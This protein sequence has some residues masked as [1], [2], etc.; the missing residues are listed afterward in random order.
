MSAAGKSQG[1]NPQAAAVAC[2][3]AR[4]SHVFVFVC[5]CSQDGDGVSEPVEMSVCV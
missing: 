3:C 4:F 5:E 1:L 2:M